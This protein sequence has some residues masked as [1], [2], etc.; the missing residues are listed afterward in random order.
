MLC[1]Y[2]T[3]I[4][5][6]M[7]IFCLSKLLNY[8][9]NSSVLLVDFA[10]LADSC[11]CNLRIK[12]ILFLT[13]YTQFLFLCFTILPRTFSKMLS[14]SAVSKYSCLVPNLLK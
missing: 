12:R 6:C 1:I 11:I 4:Y 10:S 3:A 9:M 2:M 8:L 13:S 14:R 7:M 5:S